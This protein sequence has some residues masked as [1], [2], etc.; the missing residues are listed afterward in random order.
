MSD[1]QLQ[2][3][4]TLLIQYPGL[5]LE[6]Q[7]H[8][9]SQGEDA[10]NLELSQARAASVVEYL[11]LFGIDA[12]RLTPKGYGETQPAGNNDTEAGRAKNRRVELVKMP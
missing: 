5:N 9:D 3:I 11:K 1:K 2:H 4:V 7:G 8:T 6:V 12:Q 10:Y